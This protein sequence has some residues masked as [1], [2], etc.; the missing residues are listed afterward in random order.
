MDQVVTVWGEDCVVRGAVALDDGRLSD[1]VNG[2]GR[3][4]LHRVVV[5]G[6]RETRR[7]EIDGLSLALDDVCLLE[8]LG[9][10]GHP[11]RRVWTVRHRVAAE[12]GPYTVT[13]TIHALPGVH[14]LSVFRHRPA[15]V[16]LTDAVIEATGAEGLFHWETEVVGVNQAWIASISRVDDERQ[17]GG[18]LEARP[19]GSDEPVPPTV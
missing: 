4:D 12:V 18:P 2:R 10:R 14:P 7:L 16:P 3:L 1:L 15:I 11:A 6:L 19:L 17:L 9:P 8:I 5:E 13:A